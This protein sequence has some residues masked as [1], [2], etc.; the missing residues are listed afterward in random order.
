MA[1]ASERRLVMLTYRTRI[2]SPNLDTACQVLDRKRGSF[3]YIFR[4][5]LWTEFHVIK[6]LLDKPH[7]A[8]SRFGEIIQYLPLSLTLPNKSEA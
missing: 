2:I 3:A 1:Q 8:V 6:W 5:K 7:Q 4:L